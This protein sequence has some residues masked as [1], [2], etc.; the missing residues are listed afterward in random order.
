LKMSHRCKTAWYCGKSCQKAH[1]TLGQ[2]LNVLRS[3]MVA[4]Y[5]SQAKVMHHYHS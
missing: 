5:V 1:W 2:R 3:Q 4:E